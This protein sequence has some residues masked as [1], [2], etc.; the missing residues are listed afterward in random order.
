MWEL[1][2]GGLVDAHVCADLCTICSAPEESKPD[3]HHTVFGNLSYS[4]MYILCGLPFLLSAACKSMIKKGVGAEVVQLLAPHV[5]HG[6]HLVVTNIGFCLAKL[7]QVEQQ[8]LIQQR[9]QQQQS[10]SKDKQQQKKQDKKQQQEQPPQQQELPPV[11]AT[12]LQQVEVGK[13]VNALGPNLTYN[14]GNFY[15]VL[16]QPE[17]T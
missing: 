11:L 8:H 13:Y 1:P 2:G 14:P 7:L 3:I 12:V 17:L 9:K 5:K 15:Q 16:I 4:V 6:H 10:D